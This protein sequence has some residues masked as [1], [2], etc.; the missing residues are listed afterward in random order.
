[1]GESTVWGARSEMAGQFP[2]LI[3]FL[4]A[5]VDL[6]VQVHPSE[7]YARSHASVQLKDEAWY[8]LSHEPGAR[9]LKDLQPG[10]S[11]EALRNAIESN[12]IDRAVHTVPVRSGECYYLPSGTVHALGAGT[13]VAEIQTPSDTTF[14]LFDFNRVDPSTGRTRTL[15]LE[16]ALACIDFD[17]APRPPEVCKPF[18]DGEIDCTQ[19]VRATAF[20]MDRIELKQ[21]QTLVNRSK[22]PMVLIVIEGAIEV[23]V[24]G[25]ERI[26]L[27]RGG[28]TLVPA[29]CSSMLIRAGNDSVVL[30]A[31]PA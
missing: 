11:P 15:H 1:M 13:L 12:D 28:T 10:T 27:H 20:T 31:T 23:P 17:G 6:S 4:D 25:R 7:T 24:S 30:R 21:G 18:R 9:L 8:V 19:L 26:T 22:R 14:R 16:Q 5:R 29:A 2:L 3:K